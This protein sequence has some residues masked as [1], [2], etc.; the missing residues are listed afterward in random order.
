MQPVT[1]E[2]MSGIPAIVADIDKKYRKPQDRRFL[3]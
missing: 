1:A 2:A 3:S